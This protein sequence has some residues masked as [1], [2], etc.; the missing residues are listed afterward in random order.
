MLVHQ[1]VPSS[2]HQV[3]QVHQVHRIPWQ[4][5]PQIDPLCARPRSMGRIWTSRR[6]SKFKGLMAE[7]CRML[8]GQR[9]GYGS[10]P[11]DTYFSGMNMHLPAILWFTRYQGFDPSP[12]IDLTVAEPWNHALYMGNRPL[13]WPFG[14]VKYS[15]YT[16]FFDFMQYDSIPP[17]FCGS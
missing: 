14:S 3:H 11:I 1:R 5:D 15:L 8:F 9:Y 6:C 10:I 17:I 16:R 2:S 13:S 7:V 4:I 12:Y